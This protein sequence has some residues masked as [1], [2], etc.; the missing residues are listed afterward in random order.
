MNNTNSTIG[1]S[2]FLATLAGTTLMTTLCYDAQEI[3][4]VTANYVELNMGYEW[5]NREGFNFKYSSDALEYSTI[6]SFA[7]KLV[8]QS[9]DIDIEIQ[10]A[11]NK[12]FWDLL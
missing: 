5:E 1:K 8:S 7:E 2:L 3:P 9:Q 10:E 4:S 6:I 12:I 11:V